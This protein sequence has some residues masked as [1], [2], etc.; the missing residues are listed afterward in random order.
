M[1]RYF[2]IKED[3]MVI[4]LEVVN[5]GEGYSVSKIE[6]VLGIEGLREINKEEFLRLK[7]EYTA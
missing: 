1:K 2:E 4:E 5:E 7:E 3:K 6:S